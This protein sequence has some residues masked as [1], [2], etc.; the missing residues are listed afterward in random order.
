MKDTLEKMVQAEREAESIVNEAEAEAR[1]QVDDAQRRAAGIREEA[2]ANAH[3]EAQ[4]IMEEAVESAQNRKRQ[5]LDEIRAQLEPLPASVP[6][7][8]KQ[9]AADLIVKAILAEE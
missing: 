6:A 2:K 7:E 8:S 5:R 9:A 3:A 4:K 1:R